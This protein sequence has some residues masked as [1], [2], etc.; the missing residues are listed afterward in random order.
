[1]NFLYVDNSNVWI[2]GMHVSAVQTGLAPDIWIAQS[3]KICDYGWKID[4]GRLYEF[5][6]G[7]ASEVG[8]A[9]LFGSRPPANDSLWAIAR[10][11][12]FEPIVYGRNAAN[13]EKKVD[14]SIT[15][16]IMADSY[17]RMKVGE[18]EVTLVAG[19]ADYV[20]TVAQLRSRGFTFN[21]MFWD[22]AS[23]EL[24]ESASKFVPMNNSLGYLAVKG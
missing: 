1:M 21:V 16:E 7:Q 8:R 17:E 14:N 10:S 5:A 19:D 18:D 24:R 23:R 4:F 20:P 3:E 13:R 11:R 22:H 2:E 15:T 12:G 6:G 9:V